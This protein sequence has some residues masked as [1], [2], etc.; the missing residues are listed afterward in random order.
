MLSGEAP[1]V[2]ARIARTAT[3]SDERVFECSRKSMS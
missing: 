2:R 3:A 1:A